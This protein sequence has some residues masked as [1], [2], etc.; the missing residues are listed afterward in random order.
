MTDK[1]KLLTALLKE[2]RD[3]DV[4][5]IIDSLENDVQSQLSKNL[6]KRCV[7]DRCLHGTHRIIVRNKRN[8]RTRS[9]IPKDILQRIG[10]S[11]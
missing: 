8:Q 3:A 4:C 11:D 10:T 6:S 9:E 7:D 5:D 2:Q 1:H